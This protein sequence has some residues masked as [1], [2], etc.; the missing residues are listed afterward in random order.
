MDDDNDND[1]YRRQNHINFCHRHN[2]THDHHDQQPLTHLL[3]GLEPPVL[4]KIRCGQGEKR[5]TS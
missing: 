5:A 2:H 3:L 4:P 1:D